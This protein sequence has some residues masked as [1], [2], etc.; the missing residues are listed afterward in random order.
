MDS[1]I[2]IYTLLIQSLRDNL[3][4]STSIDPLINAYLSERRNGI[5]ILSGYLYNYLHR[6]ELI[7]MTPG[8]TFLDSIQLGKDKVIDQK[9]PVTDSTECLT[10]P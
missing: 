4:Q 8:Q 2:S 7:G 6:A 9:F 5:E 3:N 1:T 10:S